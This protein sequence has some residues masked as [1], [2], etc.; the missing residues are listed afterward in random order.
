MGRKVHPI[1]FRLKITRDWDARWYAEGAKFRELLQEDFKIRRFVKKLGLRAGVSRIE[2][3]RY[4]NQ[5]LVNIHTA[6]P[7]ILI[8]RKGEAVKDLRTGIEVMTDKKVKVEV[9]EIEKPDLDPTLVAENIVDQL[10][11]R[12]GHSRAMKRAISQAMRQGALGIKIEVAGRLAGGDMARREWSSEGRVPRSSLRSDL[13]YGTAEALTTF[14]RIGVKVWI[15]KGE[16]LKQ[17]DK[18]EP[19]KDVYVTP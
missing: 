2:I 17:E 14:G 7:G 4:P 1:G 8:G 10:E 16:I 3:E 12:I 6:K 9:T 5:L 18:P 15:Y 19:K 13:D 11:R